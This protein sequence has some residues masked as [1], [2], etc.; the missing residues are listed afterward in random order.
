MSA[1]IAST[2]KPFVLNRPFWGGKMIV[3]GAASRRRLAAW[4]PAGT[5]V[6]TQ[7]PVDQEAGR[8]EG[9]DPTRRGQHRVFQ[10]IYE[11]FDARHGADLW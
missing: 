9:T 6:G 11:R 4:V 8:S 5:L 7:I 1:G 2:T 10:L 3:K